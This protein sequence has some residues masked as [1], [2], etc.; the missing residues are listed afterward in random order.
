[1]SSSSPVPGS[2]PSSRTF[3]I[4]KLLPQVFLLYLKN[5]LLG[6]IFIFLSTCTLKLEL[7]AEKLSTL[8][9]L[10]SLRPL[11]LR[12]RQTQRVPGLPTTHGL[13]W[14]APSDT[15]LDKATGQ[16]PCYDCQVL[17]HD[18]SWLMNLCADTSQEHG[19]VRI[20]CFTLGTIILYIKPSQYN[21]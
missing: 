13:F 6:S 16:R 12:L 7:P 10:R 4:A 17:Q 9:G 8:R 3:E 5:Q 21:F 14:S 11:V 15:V 18:M 20:C 1:M 2:I 19:V